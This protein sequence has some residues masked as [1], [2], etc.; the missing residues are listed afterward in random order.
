MPARH[1]LGVSAAEAEES[2]QVTSLKTFIELIGEK[3]RDAFREFSDSG[4]SP[5]KG[6][7]VRVLFSA[8]TESAGCPC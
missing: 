5:R 7:E 8:L 3:C 1:R 6:V 2:S 4:S